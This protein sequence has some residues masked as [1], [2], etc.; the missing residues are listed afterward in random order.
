M[1]IHTL[2]GLRACSLILNPFSLILKQ[3][4]HKM[5]GDTY[6]YLFSKAIKDKNHVK[7]GKRKL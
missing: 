5:V 4:F 1:K 2:K 7:Q 6:D 3:S